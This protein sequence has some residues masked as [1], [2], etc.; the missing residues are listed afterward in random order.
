MDNKRR[1]F[2]AIIAGAAVIVFVFVLALANSHQ[3][4]VTL[5]ISKE[6][7]L[8]DTFSNAVAYGDN[9]VV[10]SNGRGFVTYNYVSGKSVQL[11]PDNI[12]SGLDSLDN[13][14][15]SADKRYIF[16][17]VKHT[18]SSSVLSTMLQAEGADTNG[19]YWWTY[20][21]STK[22]FHR[23]HLG[24][25]AISVKIDGGRL[26][27]LARDDNGRQAIVTFSLPD[28]AQ[29]SS[30]VIP[31][32]NDF[33]IAQDGFLLSAPG[34]GN[35]SPKVLL[36]K[37]GVVSTTYFNDATISNISPDK[38]Y[39][40]GAVSLGSGRQLV[41][42]DLQ[43]RTQQVIANNLTGQ[44]VW[45]PDNSLLY[46]TGTNDS[47]SLF[48]YNAGTGKAKIVKIAS[49]LPTSKAD[50]TPPIALLNQTTGIIS[51]NDK[52]FLIGTNIAELKPLNPSYDKT[53][54]TS[55]GDVE[56]P[57]YTDEKAFIVSI[58]DNSQKQAVYDQLR[59]DGYNPDLV[60]IR[61]DLFVAPTHGA[62]PPGI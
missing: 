20:D 11:T 50:S 57:Y 30:L 19:T 58:R 52:K 17:H 33:F 60:E 56:I 46:S 39:G 21:T 51:Y 62:V 3:A 5:G 23:L 47:Q 42:F 55:Q 12:L 27:A 14:G 29:I 2:Y 36:T 37:D 41:L 28:L 40:I 25:D 1:Q 16:F 53:I 45:L 35:G 59:Q 31:D 44:Y 38:H 13:I 22:A 7:E 43:K 48:V 8:P 15:T 61:F 10:L 9:T 49:G 26:Y 34:D 24:S 18:T 6:Y 32:C 4:S 54:T